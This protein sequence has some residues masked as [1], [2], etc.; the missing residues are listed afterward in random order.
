MTA[1]T[2]AEG[3]RP[4]LLT[5]P[6]FY[7]PIESAVSPDA[8][9]V[10]RRSTQW[11]EKFG[12]F[13]NGVQRD[14][15]ARGKTGYFA[16][17]SLPTGTGD[18]FQAAS[19]FLLWLYTFD[20]TH[21]DERP[22]GTT[23]E[24][25]IVTVT[26][27]ARIIEAPGSRVLAG[28]PWAEALRDLRLRLADCATATQVER[29]VVE[30]TRYFLG[31]P[32]EAA[33]RRRGVEP[34]LDDYVV[35]WSYVA[36]M[37]PSVMFTDIAGGY[38][39]PAQQM[40]AP[41]VRALTEMSCVLVAWD[42][43]IIS[44]NKEAYRSSR[45]SFSAIQNLISVIAHQQGCPPQQAMG[46]AVA[47]RDRVMCLFLALQRQVLTTAGEELARYVTGLGQWVRGYLDFSFGSDRYADPVN[48]DDPDSVRIAM[49][50]AW[51]DEPVDGRLQ[52]LPIPTIAWWWNQLELA[53][54]A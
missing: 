17:Y 7:C 36:A 48:P 49:P 45:Y 44:Y 24:E 19:D 6:P 4:M 22:G 51:A 39:V 3:V 2:D 8:E 31:L 50:K 12:M 14:Y 34:S 41:A 35:M 54:A 47:M 9:L 46:I 23:P 33:N 37:L 13:E 28:N 52:P 1:I 11:L 25:L 15:L 27:L 30:L 53:H 43:D 29:W 40:S 18:G 42:N 16:A 10:D 5:V 38:E 26:Q 20:D 21:C 32:W